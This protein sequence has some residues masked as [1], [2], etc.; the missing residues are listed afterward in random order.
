M[1]FYN[2]E[3]HAYVLIELKTAKLIPEYVE[4]Q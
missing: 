4:K 3:L 1:V 2:K